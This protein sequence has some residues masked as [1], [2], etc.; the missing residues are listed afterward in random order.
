MLQYFLLAVCYWSAIL[1][2]SPKSSEH[3]AYEPGI[4]ECDPS[5]GLSAFSPSKKCR[6]RSSD[7]AAA[8]SCK[9][10]RDLRSMM[11]QLL[12]VQRTTCRRPGRVVSAPALLQG[13]QD[14]MSVMGQLLKPKKTEITDKLRQEINKARASPRH[15]LCLFKPGPL[16]F[17]IGSVPSY[18][19][20]SLTS[21]IAVYFR[22]AWVASMTS[23]IAVY[24][25]PAWLACLQRGQVRPSGRYRPLTL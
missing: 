19:L 20:A 22:P 21:Y 7:M 14:V 13:G 9:A 25:R 4:R 15:C 6:R 24:Y 16:A 18:G 8:D 11:R 12:C 23:Y 3:T 1:L 10:G 17:C 2:I 5:E